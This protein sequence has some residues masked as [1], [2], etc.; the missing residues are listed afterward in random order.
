MKPLIFFLMQYCFEFTI[1]SVMEQFQRFPVSF[2]HCD[3]D[4]VRRLLQVL[5]TLVVIAHS[6]AEDDYWVGPELKDPPRVRLQLGYY[7]LAFLST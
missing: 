2:S 6:R 7:L 5:N 3:N 4:P 1:R